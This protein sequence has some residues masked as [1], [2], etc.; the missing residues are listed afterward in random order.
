MPDFY[1]LMRRA[2]WQLQPETAHN[3]ALRVLRAGLGVLV[4]DRKSRDPDP[5]ILGQRLWGLQFRNPVGV[6]AGFD[7]DGIA[8]DALLRLGFGAVEVGTITP[9]PQ[10]GYP[11]PRVFR[12]DGD[13]A[14]INRMGF[15]S[16]G[17]DEVA[18]RLIKRRKRIGIL[19]VNLGKNRHTEIA[20]SDY[21][22][23]IR[24]M[25]PLAD[26]LV[27]NV[28]SPNTPGLRDLQRRAPLE[29][30]LMR[31]VEARGTTGVRPPLLIKIAPDLT[32]EERADIAA[33]SLSAG[34]DGIVIANTT[35]SRPP[36]LSAGISGSLGGLSGRPLFELSTELL[37][38]MYRLTS[39]RIPLIGVGGVSNAEDAY[40]KIRAG[41]SLVQVHSALVFA[42]MSLVGQIKTGLVRLISAD[43]FANIADA[44]G[45]DHRGSS[46]RTENLTQAHA[47]ERRPSHRYEA[48]RNFPALSAGN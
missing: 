14:I 3:V 33:V 38:D 2:L 6:A 30:L 32:S 4:S 42:G 10:S 15:P 26:Y 45:A 31:L 24:R 36:S 20:N 13:N 37:F 8:P 41:A 34:I 44:V 7:K 17:L 43:G 35:I 5:P 9:Q 21:V 46:V 47:P 12:L 25:T 23:G 40:G 48:P 29:E 11:R 27:I 22:E 1:P 39:G 16:A 28:S 18:N 19:G